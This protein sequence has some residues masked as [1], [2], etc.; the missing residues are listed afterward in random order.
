MEKQNPSIVTLIGTVVKLSEVSSVS[1]ENID[2]DSTVVTLEGLDGKVVDLW[3]NDA[4]IEEFGLA[5]I[6]FVGNVVSVNAEERKAGLTTY[7]DVNGDEQFHTVDQLAS[8]NASHASAIAMYKGGAPEFI[9]KD[10]AALRTEHQSA[11][12]RTQKFY[13]AKATNTEDV[14]GQIA[15]LERKLVLATGDVKNQIA[16]RIIELKQQLP[17]KA[18]AEKV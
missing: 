12:L 5:G 11:S 18:K 16:N 8:L 4:M 13:P 2:N 7:T 9:I 17:A 10:V 14:A 1:H 3:F 15:R 6:L